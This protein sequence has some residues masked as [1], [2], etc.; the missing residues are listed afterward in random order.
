MFRATNVFLLFLL[1]ANAQS[2]LPDIDLVCD[3]SVNLEVRPGS[4]LTAFHVY[5]YQQLLA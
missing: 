1:V 3:G 2:P 5:S 4:T